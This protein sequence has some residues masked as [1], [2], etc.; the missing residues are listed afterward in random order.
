MSLTRQLS[1]FGMATVPRKA[2][3]GSGPDSLASLSQ[4]KL[5]ALG[6]PVAYVDGSRRYRFVNKAFVEWTGLPVSKVIGHKVEEV[7][8]RDA[9]PLFEA[10]V[11][12]ALGGE[13]TGFERQL[14]VPGR[15]SIWIRVDYYPDRGT[16]GDVRGFLVTYAD[17]DQLKRLELEA[18]WREHRLRLV[19]DSVGSPIVHFDRQLK[20][21][22]ANKPFGNWIGANPDDLLG[23]PVTG[24][25]AGTF[26]EM[27]EFIERAFDGEKVS[28]ERRERKATGELRWVRITLFPDRAVGGHVGGVFAVMTDIEDDIAIRDALKAQEVQLRLIADNIPGPIAYLDRASTYTFVNQAFANWVRRPQ[29]QIYGRTPFEVL[30]PDVASFMR[31]VLERAQGGENIEY[32]RIDAPPTTCS[33]GCTAASRPTS[34]RRGNCAASI[35]PNT[36]S[37]ISR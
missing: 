37:T 13:R 31:P 23:R 11:E 19:T 5:N 20:V 9:Y 36:T 21:R 2:S 16:D 27:D 25:I 15:P 1:R 6:L 34:T 26:A 14:T 10:Y 17:V 7:A 35:A 12:A 24:L 33:G 4:R 3:D 8:G 28:F 32:E 22:F 30:A 18:G 29:D